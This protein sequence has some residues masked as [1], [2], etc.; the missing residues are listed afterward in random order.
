MG[1][2]LEFAK[3]LGENNCLKKQLSQKTTTTTT[4]TKWIPSFADYLF[5]SVNKGIWII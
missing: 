2:S 5:D 3:W 4:T 1:Y